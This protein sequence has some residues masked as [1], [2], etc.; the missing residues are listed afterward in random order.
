MPKGLTA[1]WRNPRCFPGV[2]G[3]YLSVIFID[4]TR[5]REIKIPVVQKPFKDLI[6]DYS[7]T[8]HVLL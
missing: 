5:G 8:F 7:E 2:T 4:C 3:M 6:I 1:P